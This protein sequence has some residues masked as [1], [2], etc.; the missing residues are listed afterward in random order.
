MI[1]RWCFKEHEVPEHYWTWSVIATDGSVA[2]TS[3]QHFADYG[4]AVCEAIRNGFR[5]T[6]DEWVVESLKSNT[7]FSRGKSV[8]FLPGATGCPPD[9]PDL[10]IPDR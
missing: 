10:K 1:P 2:R 7:Y 4:A 5:P 3:Q 9:R 6:E 8:P